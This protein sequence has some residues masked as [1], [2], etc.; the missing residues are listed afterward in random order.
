M[1]T[2]NIFL[3]CTVLCSSSVLYFSYLLILSKTGINDGHGHLGRA[4]PGEPKAS[5]NSQA[6]VFT[7]QEDVNRIYA[8]LSNLHK[9]F[10]KLGVSYWID[11]GTL[12]GAVRHGGL[13][14]WD[15]D[16]DMSVMSASEA[17]LYS[18][19]FLKELEI[20]NYTI[21]DFFPGSYKVF[22]TRGKLISH[23]GF[24]YSF[25]AVDIFVYAKRGNVVEHTGEHWR[26]KTPNCSY[27]TTHLFPL[28]LYTFKDFTLFGPQSPHAFLDSCY[29]RNWPF[30]AFQG[31]DHKHELTPH[32]T[33]KVLLTDRDKRPAWWYP[34]N[35]MCFQKKSLF[36][37]FHTS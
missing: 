8:L 2:R 10:K 23:C 33:K 14:P 31:Y 15:D 7:G 11:F 28:K 16:A 24:N 5:T 4:N 37:S 18:P 6:L 27:F 1:A 3:I 19:A 29:G 26:R 9:L 34:S 12:L 36:S 35:V 32:S 21:I 13:I 22:S 17:A 30:E 25:P 20:L